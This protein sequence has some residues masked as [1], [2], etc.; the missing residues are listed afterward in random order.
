VKT[1]KLYGNPLFEK[2][3]S[4]RPELLAQTNNKTLHKPH[5]QTLLRIE[6]LL[7][8]LEG[9]GKRPN[10][11]LAYK[12]NLYALAIRAD[13]NNP[14]SV[15][16]AIARYKC[17]DPK[18]RKLTDRPASNNYKSNLCDCY[19]T[20]CKLYGL[21]WEKPIYQPQPTSIQPPSKEQIEMLIS[22]AKGALSLKIHISMETGLRPIEVQGEIGLKAKDVHPEQSKNLMEFWK[23]KG[24]TP[25][26]P[27]KDILEE[28]TKTLE[29]I[30]KPY[31]ELQKRL[32]IREVRLLPNPTLEHIG[33]LSI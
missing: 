19:A 16:L 3:S 22:A 13:L 2:M 28:L 8:Y 21:T 10:T 33:K 29:R 25:L 24:E 14:T 15:E 1:S 30:I 31:R 11:V 5:I 27:G 17:I 20:Y 7:T 18:T 32:V 4:I 12:K 26:L 6:Q 23:T 9:K